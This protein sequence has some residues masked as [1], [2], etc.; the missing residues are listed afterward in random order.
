[1]RSHPILLMIVTFLAVTAALLLPKLANSEITSDELMCDPIRKMCPVGSTAIITPENCD[2]PDWYYYKPM[3]HGHS[4]NYQVIQ[5]YREKLILPLQG[6]R[7]T[8]NGDVLKVRCDNNSVI[9]FKPNRSENAPYDEN[10]IY[11]FVDIIE[12]SKS[13][14]I[15]V[16]LY[17]GSY[18]IVLNYSNGA[19]IKLADLPFWSPSGKKFID[20]N[21]SI[22]GYTADAFTLWTIQN[23]KFVKEFELNPPGAIWRSVTWESDTKAFVTEI[24]G[25][26]NNEYVPS[27]RVKTP[28]VLEYSHGKWT[29]KKN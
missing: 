5:E 14:V 25:I 20:S 11:Y 6:N 9:E 17:E 3:L 15:F 27:K 19:Q 22:S 18:V 21:Y 8:K 28:F 1:M 10:G 4:D 24:K 26:D 23:G 16:G 2:H 12:P 13:I 7:V 29:Y